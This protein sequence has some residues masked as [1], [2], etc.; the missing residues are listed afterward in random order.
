MPQHGAEVA[1]IDRPV[2]QEQELR[3]GE[4]AFPQDA[5]ARD[6]RLALVA[7]AHDRRGQR[8]VTRLAVAPQAD[9]RGHDDGEERR[10]ELLQVVA[11]VEI[12][13]AR[14]ADD[15]RGEERVAPV[16]QRLHAHIRV[17][18]HLR[19]VAVVIAER[20]LGRSR[21]GRDLADEA[22]LGV[23]DQGQRGEGGL[24][25]AQASAQRQ[26]REQE[27]A[28]VLGQRR[29]RGQDQGG[30]A[31]QEDVHGQRPAEALGLG[32]VEPAA[33]ADLRVHADRSVVEELAAVH[34]QV[35]AAGPRVLGVHERQGQETAPVAGP[36][37]ERG[38]ALEP[39]RIVDHLRDA[40][41][42]RALEPDPRQAGQRAALRPELARAG[43]DELLGQAGRLGD[44][45]GGQLPEREL[46]PSRAAE[47]V[48]HQRERGARHAPEE[49]RRAAGGDHPAVD[50]GHLEVRVDR[51]LDLDQ[52]A[53]GAQPV[54]EGVQVSRGVHG[55]ARIMAR[56][57]ARPLPAAPGAQH[58]VFFRGPAS[59]IARR[60]RLEPKRRLAASTRFRSWTDR[61]H[62]QP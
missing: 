11:E 18:V 26:A 51:R 42:A 37:P 3:Q 32:Q 17:V 56:G 22:E 40:R 59:R 46:D 50:L 15:G 23:G 24:R 48:R 41:A 9:D 25:R 33:L 31:A 47:E 28:D 30:R 6:H 45:L 34:A 4:L 57:D 16:Q 19:V 12:L 36:G 27:L 35:V 58:P 62:R 54:D 21:A 61:H 49:E 38:Q 60:L 20:P 1:Q 7:L 8:V 39:R 2:G 10:Q 43:R 5:E 53:G 52:L 29:D 13:L 14:L 44:E 55:G